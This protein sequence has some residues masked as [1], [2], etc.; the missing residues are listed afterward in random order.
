MNTHLS[1][2]LFSAAALV[3][4]ISSASP[5]AFASNNLTIKSGGGEELTVKNGLFGGSQ[6]I[7]KDRFGNGYE[8]KK[9]WFGTK[10]AKVSVLGNHVE[11]KKGLLGSTE[12]EAT[13]ILGDKVTTKKGLFGNRK[14]TVELGGVSS[15]IGQLFKKKP[16]PTLSVPQTPMSSSSQGTI[17]ASPVDLQSN[18]IPQADSAVPSNNGSVI[19]DVQGWSQ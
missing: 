8:S 1:R 12:V 16:A 18:Q 7:V 2:H 9:G 5:L 14:T 4:A 11:K 15:M 17:E 3:I 13:S 19:E 10:K 6:K